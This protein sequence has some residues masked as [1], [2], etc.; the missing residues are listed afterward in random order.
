MSRCTKPATMG[1]V[2]RPCRLEPDEQRLAGAEQR[3]AVEQRPQAA[4]GQVL[5]DDE[6][7]LVVAPVVDR[8]DVRMAECGRGAGLGPEP[9]QEV[10]VVGQRLVQHLDGD[11]TAQP[12]VVGQEHLGRCTQADRGD[13]AVPLA[14]HP[15]DLGA[16][17][18]RGH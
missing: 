7:D 18:R 15:A 10:G 1:V 3:A 17:A 5:G 6:R 9:A 2:E 12:G 14:Q 4:A 16:H 13:D 11:T 8:D